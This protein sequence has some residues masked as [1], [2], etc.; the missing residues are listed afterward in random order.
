MHSASPI[1]VVQLKCWP[2]RWASGEGR[3]ERVV[4]GR[5]RR[6]RRSLRSALATRLT[7]QQERKHNIATGLLFRCSAGVASLRRRS[8]R[9]GRFVRQAWS[10]KLV[11][12][13]RESV[14]W[15]VRGTDGDSKDFPERCR[16]WASKEKAR[17]IEESLAPEATVTAVAAAC[18]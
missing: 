2:A 1:A 7:C 5:V 9:P 12:E 11:R 10:L 15:R 6:S 3:L 13:R 4:A 16:R 8:R 17:I 18:S 14:N